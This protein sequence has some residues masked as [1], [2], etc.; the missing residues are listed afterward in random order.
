MEGREEN[1]SSGVDGR[2]ALELALA[3]YHSDARGG[4]RVAVPLEALGLRVPS[5]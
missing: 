5:R 3:V 4:A 2:A 1:R